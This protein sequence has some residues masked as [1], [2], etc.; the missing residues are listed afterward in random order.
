MLSPLTNILLKIFAAGFYRAHSGMLIFLFGTII[1]Y[2][3]FIN[4]LGTVPIWAFAEWNL[5][6]TLSLVSNPF[7]LLVFF[8]ICF[9]YAVKSLQYNAAQL[10]LKTNEFLY[11]SCSSVNKYQQFKSWFIV[12]LNIFLPLWIY[13]L[14]A[15]IVGV[16][17]GHYVIPACILIYLF[18]LTGATTL[19]YLKIV[20]SLI[21]IN[22][23]TLFMRLIKGWNKPFFL[24]YSFFVFNKLKLA[25]LIT[26]I[27]SWIFIV[28]MVSLFS[29]LEND[30]IIPA[31]I[32]LILITTHSILIYNEYR[33]TETSLYFSHNFPYSKNKLFLGFSANYLILMLPELLWLTSKYNSIKVVCIICMGLSLLL[34]F[35]SLLYWLGLDIKKF[36]FCVFL[37]FNV[38]FLVILYKAA[39]YL[40]PLNF[41]IAYFIFTNNYSNQS[42]KY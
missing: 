38:F 26:K 3:F 34:L 12:Q 8:F 17:Y 41:L 9:G 31:I 11:F 27:L 36:L 24:L 42:L 35:R 37:L 32:M 5:I 14:F 2:C 22:K 29:D 18:V 30:I 39:L 40:L 33:F 6:I 13:G 1:S 10:D 16:N 4:T 19:T 28:G 20:N 23:Q 15:A 21:D 25:Y 7:I